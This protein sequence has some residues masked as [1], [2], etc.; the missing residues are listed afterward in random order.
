MVQYWLAVGALSG[1]VWAMIYN[2]RDESIWIVSVR[3]VGI[4]KD[5]SM[6]FSK[7]NRDQILAD[8]NENK[9][10]SNHFNIDQG[11][12]IVNV[13]LPV[14]AIKA[15]DK[16]AMRRN[17]ARQALIRMWLIDRLDDLSKKE[18]S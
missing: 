6:K 17:V 3:K 7:T 18:A 14:W 10:I 8:F 11:A 16:E 12:K 5:K 4:M 2:I 13:E 1:I 9:D 15:L